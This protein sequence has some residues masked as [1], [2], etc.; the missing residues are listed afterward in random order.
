[1]IIVGAIVTAGG[2][3]WLSRIPVHG[4]FLTDLLPGMLV[5][6]VGIGAMF[7]AVATAANAGVRADQAGLAAALLNSAQQVGG[8]LGLAVLSAVATARTSP[9]LAARTPAPEALTAG[10]QRALLAGSIALAAS[11]IIAF[12]VANTRHQAGAAP[13]P[14]QPEP[15]PESAPANR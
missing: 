10:F 12:W 8:A 5:M 13:A 14:Q 1:L 3:Y 15:Q 2:V 4:S 9:L 11:A 6:S 7:V